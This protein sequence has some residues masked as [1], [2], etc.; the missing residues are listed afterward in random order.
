M[1]LFNNYTDISGNETR[2]YDITARLNR[3][4]DKVATKIMSADGRWQW[5]DTNYASSDQ[6][7]GS[8]TLTTDQQDYTIDVEHLSI[9]KVIALDSSGNKYILKPIDINDPES[10]VMLTDTSTNGGIPQYY[11]KV[12]TVLKLYPIPNYT[13]TNGLI[14]HFQRKPSYFTYTDSSKAAGIPAIFHRYLSLSAAQDYAIS[15]SMPVKND[16]E[17][18][19]KEIEDDIISFYSKRS[20]DEQKLIRGVFRSSR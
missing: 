12:G 10:D 4:Y 5:D 1:L 14:V 19:I 17:I 18:K 20:K 15:K 6:P 11:D 8:T 7:L 9:S 2:L 3:A 13:K 16:W